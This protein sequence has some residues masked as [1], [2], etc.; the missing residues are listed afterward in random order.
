MSGQ[1]SCDITTL[2]GGFANGCDDDINPTGDDYVMTIVDF[3]AL[4]TL[5]IN[6]RSILR[7]S[8]LSA[9]LAGC[10]CARNF[11]SKLKMEKIN[12][13]KLNTRQLSCTG[14]GIRSKLYRV[15]ATIIRRRAAVPLCVTGWHGFR[16]HIVC[17]S[18]VN[19]MF[20]LVLS[21]IKKVSGQD[22]IITTWGLF[23]LATFVTVP[24]ATLTHTHTL[25]DLRE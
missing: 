14:T 6:S 22:K 2:A 7:I 18:S 11:V 1:L 12:T 24:I 10:E 17:Y 16:S 20:S 8:Y 5:F 3:I 13:Q 4:L 9:C 21:V 23:F 15:Q 19:N 25:V